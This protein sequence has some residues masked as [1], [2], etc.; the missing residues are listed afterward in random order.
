MAGDTHAG[1]GS[2]AIG[3]ITGALA[4]CAL[5]LLLVGYL[6]AWKAGRLFSAAPEWDHETRCD[7]AL[8]AA[9]AW[10]EAGSYDRSPT[11]KDE[12]R[13]PCAMWNVRRSLQ[14]GS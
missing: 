9:D 8:R 13:L 14:G 11:W 3:F 10:A 4:A 5:G 2:F 6:P 7:A 12:A 1:R